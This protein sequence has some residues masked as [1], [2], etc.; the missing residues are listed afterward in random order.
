MGYKF[1]HTGVVQGNDNRIPSDYRRTYK[2]RETKLFWISEHNQKYKKSNG[3]VLGA[4]PVYRLDL[5]SIH[6]IANQQ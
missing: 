3:N 2:L 5:N 1:T 6:A 4:W